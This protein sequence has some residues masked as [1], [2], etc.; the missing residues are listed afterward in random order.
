MSKRDF[1]S[2]LDCTPEELKR[3]V[4]RGT[5][6][7]DASRVDASAPHPTPLT[8][9]SAVMIFELNSTRTRVAFEIGMAQLGG[10]TV[11]LDPEHSQLGRGE[12]VS[13]MARVLSEM[14][15]VVIIL[16]SI[17]IVMGEVDR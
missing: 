5:E 14:A 13:D 7:R 9:R 15:D 3:I 16:G 12:P 17:D 11:W 6:L 2:L 1:L 10:Y 8:G 4:G